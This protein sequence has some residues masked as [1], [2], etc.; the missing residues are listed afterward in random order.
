MDLEGKITFGTLPMDVDA[1][2]KVTVVEIIPQFIK[3]VAVPGSGSG[4]KTWLTSHTFAF[5]RPGIDL[6]EEYVKW[7]FVGTNDCP[8]DSGTGQ[9]LP[10]TIA[11]QVYD[12]VSGIGPFIALVPDVWQLVRFTNAGPELIVIGPAPTT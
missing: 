3:V 12:P 4:S 1:D 10:P 5:P 2:R 11:Y 6:P 7:L 9:L 8:N